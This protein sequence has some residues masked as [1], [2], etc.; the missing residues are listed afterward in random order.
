MRPR[1]LAERCHQAA[2]VAG[3]RRED[4]VGRVDSVQRD[5]SPEEA[6]E[7]FGYLATYAGMDGPVSSAQTR[8]LLDWEPAGPALIPD[9]EAGHYCPS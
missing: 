3:P 8:K 5:L 4:D 9:I 2:L 1:D 6:Q 7:H